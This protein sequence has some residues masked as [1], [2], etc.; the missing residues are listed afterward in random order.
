[1]EKESSENTLIFQSVDPVLHWIL[2]RRKYFFQPGETK[3]PLKS[4][5]IRGSDVTVIDRQKY[6]I[7]AFP[8]NI[9]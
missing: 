2:P 6:K 8:E 7:I 9:P 5:Q 3:Q 1:M 4:Q